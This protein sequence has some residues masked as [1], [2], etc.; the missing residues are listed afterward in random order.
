MVVIFTIALV[1]YPEEGFQA[2]VAG[3]K[4]FLDV[5]FPSLLPFFILSELMLGFGVV[6]GLGV[7]LEPLM[8]PLFSVPGCGAFALSMGLAAGYPMDAVITARFRETGMCTRIE[9]ER[10][11]AFTNTADPLFMFGAVAVG[12]FE[13]PELGVLLAVAHYLSA[14]LVGV[15]FKLWGRRQEA[16]TRRNEPAP[17]VRG[18]FR[19]AYREMMKARREDGRTFGRLLHDAVTES[20]NTLLMICG[21]IMFFAVLIEILRVSGI[22]RVLGWPIALIYHVFGIHQ[23][24]VNPTLAGLLEIDIGTAQTA[25]AVAP[26]LQKVALASA[27]IAWSGLAVHAQVASVLTQTDIRMSPYFLARFLHAVLAAF[28]TVVFWGL[29][30]GRPVAQTLAAVAPAWAAWAQGTGPVPWWLMLTSSM[31]TWIWLVVALVAVSLVFALVRR[32]GSSL[33]YAR[34][35]T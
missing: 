13:S 27:I 8:K 3:L 26:L 32:I 23:T 16:G 17:A 1:V 12:M 20:I 31:R 2:G 35:R 19:R 15:S 5:V 29:G 28:F 18:I 30:L 14:F 10:L 7:L 11:L 6:H 9:G 25:A 4:V 33:R 21:F 22:I 34:A 24:L